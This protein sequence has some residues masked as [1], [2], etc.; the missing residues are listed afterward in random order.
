MFNKYSKIIGRE[1]RER[2][3]LSEIG[4]NNLKECINEI[5]VD[6]ITVSKC[7]K[8]YAQTEKVVQRNI[9]YQYDTPFTL[10]S[11]VIASHQRKHIY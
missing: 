5:A 3:D 2:L 8:G 7:F 9:V 6:N 1:R 10:L 4:I 11:T